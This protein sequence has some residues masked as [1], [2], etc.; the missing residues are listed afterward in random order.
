MVALFLTKKEK[1]KL[2]FCASK[3]LERLCEAIECLSLRSLM[4]LIE[5][6]R[7]QLLKKLSYNPITMKEG[8]KGCFPFT[9]LSQKAFSPG[10]ILSVIHLSY[11]LYNAPC[12][13]GKENNTKH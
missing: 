7:A 3:K 9:R 10:K 5:A 6:D 4:F 12:R 2:N 11:Q 1:N 8:S 13:K